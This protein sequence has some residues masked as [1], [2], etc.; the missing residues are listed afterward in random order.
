MRLFSGVCGPRESSPLYVSL[1]RFR[2]DLLSTRGNSARLFVLVALFIASWSYRV[3]KPS[4][5]WL[6]AQFRSKTVARREKASE[7]PSI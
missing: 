6:I 4:R 7:N 3:S 1:F 2:V 5:T